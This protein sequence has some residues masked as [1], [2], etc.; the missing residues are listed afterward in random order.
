MAPGLQPR[1]IAFQAELLF[2]PI[3]L[4]ADA[5]QGI[6]NTLFGKPELRYQNFQVAHDGIHLANV[7]ATP[8]AVSMATFGADR[9]IIREELNSTTVDE[10]ATRVVNVS[11]IG[12][13]A[14]NI[15]TTVAQQFIVRSLM[16]PSQAEPAQQFLANRAL[17]GATEHLGQFGRPLGVM[18][19]RFAF[20]QTTAQGD[21]FQVRIEPWQRDPQSLWIENHGTFPTPTSRED[22]PNVGEQLYAAYRFLTG[23]V[24]SFLES[25]GQP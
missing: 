18:G 15:P 25:L 12:F 5:L 24:A 3:Q 6:H 9:L 17:A 16:N 8:G 19:L 21:N 2:P 23:P 1:T 13:E 22:L 7:P 11:R 14:L 20:P 10:F 4:R